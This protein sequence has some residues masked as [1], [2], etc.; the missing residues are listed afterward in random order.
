MEVTKKLTINTNTEFDKYPYIDTFSYGDDGSLNNYGAGEYTYNNT[1]GTRSPEEEDDDHE[2]EAYDEINEE[3]I[4]EDDAIYI[5]YGER[6]YRGRTTHRDVCVCTDNDRWYHEDDD[7]I[8]E[9]GGTW[10]EKDSDKIREVDGEWYDA[11]DVVYSE[12][13][14]TDYLLDDC[15][16]SE[17]MND[18]ILRDDAVEI[19]GEWYHKDHE[20]VVQIDGKYYHKDNVPKVKTKR[21]RK[22]AAMAKTKRTRKTAA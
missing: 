3:Y 15:V 13:D 10:Y 19:D 12:W 7:N 8:V 20:D 22:I 14:S 5:E 21:I 11:D 18:Y 4:C 1:D 17:P 2:G 16:H 9:V 6:R